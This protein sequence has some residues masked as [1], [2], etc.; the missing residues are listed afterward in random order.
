[1]MLY[2][3]FIS[4]YHGGNW[5]KG[6]QDLTAIISNNYMRIYNY[7]KIESSFKKRDRGPWVAQLVERPILVLAQVVIS[8]S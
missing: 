3:S 2:Y 4:Y 8:G 7:L 6:T 1:M 5:A